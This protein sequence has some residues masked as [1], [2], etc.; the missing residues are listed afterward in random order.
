[1]W[2]NV[3]VL[4]FGVIRRYRNHRYYVRYTSSLYALE[5]AERAAAAAARDIPW[6]FNNCCVVSVRRRQMTRK[7]EM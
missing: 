5:I 1:M 6:Y 4:R 3:F 7:L 2:I